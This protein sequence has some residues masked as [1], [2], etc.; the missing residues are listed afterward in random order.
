MKYRTINS[1]DDFAALRES[2][3]QLVGR[4]YQDTVF[5]KHQW[6]ESWWKAYGDRHELSVAI[7]QEDQHIQGAMPLMK[8]RERLYG[9]PI[10]KIS[11]I[12]NN[13][14]PHCGPIIDRS[15]NLASATR[16][17]L[18]YVTST[19]KHWDVIWLQRMVDNQEM[20]Q[21]MVAYCRD[22]GYPV[23]S[24]DS[25]H[26]PVLRLT[27]DWDTYYAGKT[28]RF[29]KK[30]RNDL[31][32]LKRQG[33]LSIEQLTS[34][35][36]IQERFEDVF[37]VGNRSWK[38]KININIGSSVQNRRF[39]VGLPEWIASERDGVILWTLSVDEK[40]IA[41]EYHVQ[42]DRTLFALRSEFD[43]DYGA[44][45]P[46][47]VLDSE[48]VKRLFANGIEVYNM[49][50]DSS[51]YK[52]RWTSE[53]QVH[54]DVIV[55]NRSVYGRM[56]SLIEAYGRSIAKRLLRNRPFLLTVARRIVRP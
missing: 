24:R 28:Q 53:A 37:R 45:S 39:F 25:L 20:I 43:Q 11:F 17:L 50:G 21:P 34:P 7:S 40:M 41:F 15:L 3:N 35:V 46:G 16:S 29:K 49:C 1:F 6:F 9:L 23:I 48:I 47:A 5:F 12:A 54:R 33:R 18:D 8:S 27:T 10:R 19:E 56:V 30:I 32:R 2:W 52:L 26:S 55:C 14:I 31:N 42:G 13:E 44:H 22:Q 51:P 38:K 36:L 4:S